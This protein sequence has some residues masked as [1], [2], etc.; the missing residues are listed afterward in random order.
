MV[1]FP[2]DMS[3][4]RDPW[5]DARDLLRTAPPKVKR[6]LRFNM[7]A[8]AFGLAVAVL[9]VMTG[10]NEWELYRLL[11]I[12]LAMIGIV[13]MSQVYVLHHLSQN[14]DPSCVK[15]EMSV[16]R[17]QSTR[18]HGVLRGVAFLGVLSV[19]AFAVALGLFFPSIVHRPWLAA[20]GAIL[21][22]YLVAALRTVW[23]L[24][25]FMY[26]QARE[27]AEAAARAQAEATAAQLK[28]LQVQMQPH[29]L[30]NAL[31]TV[32]A[33]V[34]SDPRQ[35]ERTVEDLAQVLRRGLDRSRR[36]TGTV[37][38]EIDFIRAWLAVEQQ[39]W[40]ER[41]V[42]LWDVAEDVLE[43]A[44]P[45]MTLQPLVENALKHGLSG[46][47]AGGHIT[48]G[49]ARVGDGLRLTV[50]DDG[51]GMSPDAADGTGLSNVRQRLRTQ[52]GDAARLTVTSQSNGTVVD[53]HLPI[54]EEV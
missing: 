35:A 5:S 9:D 41:L 26:Q 4:I 12:A 6:V 38:D 22:F 13:L 19:L 23:H 53:L 27:Q 29:F 21:A 48:V 24:M 52:Y 25:D 34:R 8:A 46:R 16:F 50:T 47:L 32:A 1:Q 43:I 17:L 40:G 30:F 11:G 45:P 37:G 49:A 14:E 3:P 54:L 15:L 2:P 7:M 10:T 28:T 18:L 44:M 36:S 31:N 42:V 51:P 20:V 33:L 39:R